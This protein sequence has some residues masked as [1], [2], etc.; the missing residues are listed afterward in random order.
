MDWNV[1]FWY[2]KL[3]EIVVSLATLKKHRLPNPSYHTCLS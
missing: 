1:L 3:I 2:N